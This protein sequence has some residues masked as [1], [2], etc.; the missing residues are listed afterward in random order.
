VLLAALVAVPTAASEP[1]AVTLR[2]GE[3]LPFDTEQLTAAV[4]LRVPAPPATAPA[5]PTIRV[6]RELADAVRIEIGTQIR[7]VPLRGRRGLA[8][9]RVV[10]LAIA[11]LAT[12]PPSLPEPLV[13]ARAPAPARPAALDLALVLSLGGGS[14]GDGLVVAP[15]LD[16]SV[17]VFGPLRAVAEAG[18]SPGPDAVVDGLAVSLRATPLR[19]GLAWRAPGSALELRALALL[20][21]YWVSGGSAMTPIGRSG[22]VGGGSA[23][24]AYYARVAG[25]LALVLATGLDVFASR[26]ELRIHGR[27]AVATER[28]LVSGLLGVGWSMRP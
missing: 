13:G 5:R 10:A 17:P 22:V 27:D 21:P 9:A 26:D 15:A 24:G 18:Y 23:M 3:G 14:N 25:G 16:V 8:A 28:V 20:L 6:E 11:D 19:A 1:T 12:P 7:V 2:L 4:A